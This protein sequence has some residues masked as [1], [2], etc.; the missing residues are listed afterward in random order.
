MFAHTHSTCNF[1]ILDFSHSFS[2]T[3]CGDLEAY[4]TI[5]DC[6]KDDELFSAV[7]DE[8]VEE[9]LTH[10]CL[11]IRLVLLDLNE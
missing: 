5:F 8:D 3:A 6:F 1:F 2:F 7:F 4:E 9:E 10:L 11:F